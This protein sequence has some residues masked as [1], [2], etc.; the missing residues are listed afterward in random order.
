MAK[1]ETCEFC[2]D[3]TAEMFLYARCHP[4]APLMARKEGPI[5]ILSCY[6]PECAREVARF[7]ILSRAAS[8][9]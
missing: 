3:V 1:I 6:L 7:T 9:D 2:D 8:E 4:T 5:L